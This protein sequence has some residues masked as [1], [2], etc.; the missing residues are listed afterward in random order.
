MYDIFPQ[1]IKNRAILCGTP[2]FMVITMAVSS[3][4]GAAV[5]QAI[6]PQLRNEGAAEG[7]RPDGDGDRDDI[8]T[9]SPRANTSQPTQVTESIGKNLNVFA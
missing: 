7:V 6:L 4:G 9:I 1:K 2:I 5:Q 8:N 3:I